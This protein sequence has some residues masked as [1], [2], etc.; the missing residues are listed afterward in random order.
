MTDTARRR[1]L[2]LLR[3]IGALEDSEVKGFLD[4]LG[5]GRLDADDVGVHLSLADFFTVV[6]QLLRTQ[7]LH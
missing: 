5:S 1:A 2:E 4:D 6:E 3:D 7:R